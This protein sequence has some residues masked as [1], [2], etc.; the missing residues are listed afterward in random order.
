MQILEPVLGCT[1]F[2]PKRLDA[3]S[4]SVRGILRDRDVLLFASARLVQ[5]ALQIVALVHQLLEVERDA[6]PR[7]SLLVERF[8]QLVALRLDRRRL[9]NERHQ[10]K[11]IVV[12]R[13]RGDAD[14]RPLL[15]GVAEVTRDEA[16]RDLARFFDGDNTREICLGLQGRFTH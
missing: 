9:V 5:L 4:Q 3:A 6:C 12:R 1:R 2:I 13:I 11:V 16:L 15:P 14:P 8:A 10:P 7:A